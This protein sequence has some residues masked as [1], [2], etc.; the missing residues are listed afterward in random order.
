ME[1]GP[2]ID[3]FPIKTSIYKGFS[4]VMLNN[5]MVNHPDHERR[6]DTSLTFANWFSMSNRNSLNLAWRFGDVGPKM[7]DTNYVDPAPKRLPQW[8]GTM[9]ISC[10]LLFK[11]SHCFWPT[12]LDWSVRLSETQTS[13]ILRSDSALSVSIPL[14]S[15]YVL[16]SHGIDGPF[17]DG[18]PMFA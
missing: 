3:D 11:R 5:Q 18:L 10:H 17:T 1:N 14:P 9:F 7:S 8:A 16:H 4:M 6:D 12:H 2:F 15:G 13:G